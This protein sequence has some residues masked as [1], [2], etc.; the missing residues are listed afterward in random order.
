MKNVS[1]KL[2]GG[3]A[4]A[5]MLLTFSSA[6]YA[7]ATTVSCNS[8]NSPANQIYDHTGVGNTLLAAGKYVQIIQSSDNV[9]GIPDPSTGVPAGDTVAAFG[10]LSAA[11][12]F[13]ASCN[14]TSNNFVYIRAW[15]TWNGSGVPTGN[16]GTS[17][18]ASVLSGF[19]YTYK[20]AS[21]ATQPTLTGGSINPN[22]GNQGQ[23]LP[24]VIT[25]T[26]A[27]WSGNM[28]ASV[29]FGA[30]ITVN[31]ATGAGN[32][33]NVNIT[34]AAGAAPGARTVT[35]TG[36]SGSLTFTV[37][38]PGALTI[39]PAT[40]PNGTV[41]TAYNQTLTASGGTAPYSFSV[42]AGT[43]PA[44]LTLSAA[45]VISG[46]PTTAQAYT[47]TV[48]VTDASVPQK[49]GTQAYTV[50]ISGGGNNPNI[51]SIAPTSAYVGQTIVITGTKFGATIG[52]STL[53][54]GGVAAKPTV[55]SDTSITVAVPS[56]ASGTAVVVTTSSGSG[57]ST[58]TIN[59]GGAV[60]DDV[61][62]GS[63]GKW[64]A[65]LVQS[66]YFVFDNSLDITPDKTN[67]GT[68]LPQAEA[69]HHGS[70]GA[71]V[72]YSF[73]G[74]DGTAWGGGWG[75]QLANTLD[76]SS[77]NKISFAIKWDGSTNA[78]K[79]SLQD[80][81]GTAT[82]A[83]VTNA[84]L[85]AFNA[86]YG[87][88]DLQKTSFAYDAGGSKAAADATFDWTKVVSYS[89]VYNTPGT[90][91]NY[92]YIDCVTAGDVTFPD[93]PIPPV[94][95][96]VT[97][98]SVTPPTGPAG[99]QV[100]INGTSFG[101]MQ[102]QSQLVFENNTQGNNTTYPMTVLSWSDTSIEAIVPRLAPAGSYTLKVVKMT[103]T[104]G[105]LQALESNPQSF[106]V[107]APVPSGG[108]AIVYPNPFNPLAI[109]MTSSGLAANSI[110]IAYDAS[111]VTNIGI[112]IYDMTGRQVYHAIT[113]Q[114]QVAW[115][116]RDADG[117]IVADG[118]YLLRIVN[119]DTKSL[120][121]KGRILVI[122]K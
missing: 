30:G 87:V 47:F 102:G 50:T 66:G 15:E 122:K 1:K 44:G 88:I 96:E 19:T 68:Q 80:S 23:T 57:N 9:A 77:Y 17:T 55:W 14:I 92:H 72:K 41:G 16:Y 59:T 74:T 37:N 22:N 73:N 12:N 58:L 2:I 21:F 84:T 69:K 90:S 39:S 3:L 97:I 25:G 43:L 7:V 112:Y 105:I 24:V 36:V 110:N 94:T 119:E 33:I 109:G 10:T 52:T 46:T 89:F 51:T 85:S 71:K 53:T 62:G 60:I 61:E 26:G 99:T 107:T 100:T 4:A 5:L 67:I 86:A 121:S 45:G 38:P 42:S 63:V 48:S 83:T 101:A 98:T 106:Q 32:T 116:G 13:S 28:A 6:A 120:I 34:I 27:V 70:L 31:T 81:D 82:S 93:N 75:A 76:L 11:G 56:G 79:L 114:G 29:S 117:N 20:P 108:T 65:G 113:T 91:S 118:L 18:P 111:S 64:T 95:G 49:S 35:V 103:I 8:T 54:I 115:N 78:L 40:L 104:L